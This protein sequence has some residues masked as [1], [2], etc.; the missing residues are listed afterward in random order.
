MTTDTLDWIAK[1]ADYTPDKIAVTSYDSEERYTYS[2]LDIYANRLVEKFESFGLQEGDRIAVLAEHSLHYIVL[3]SACQRSGIIIVPLNY[4]LSISDLNALFIDSN[5]ALLLYSETQKHKLEQLSV[6]LPRTIHLDRIK[7]YYQNEVVVKPRL[8][9]IKEKNPIFIFYTSGTTGQ[10]KGVIYTNKMMFW[11]SLNTSMQLGITFRDSTINT[12]PPYHTS[13]WNIFLTPL[14]HKGAHI[15]MVEKFDAERVLCLLELN[16]TTLFMALPTMLAMMQKTEVFSRVNLDHL[17]FII[18]GGETVSPNLLKYWKEKKDIAIRPGYGLTEAGPSIT[19][20]HHNIAMSKPDSIGKPNFYLKTK[21]VTSEGRKA[22][23]NEVGE[24]CIKGDIVTSG[25]WNNSTETNNK[26][27]NGWLHTGDLVMKDKDGFLFL[28][29]RKDDMYISGGENIHPQEI[30]NKI[31]A[32]NSVVK[33]TVL[34][35]EDQVWGQCG[36]AFVVLKKGK[37]ID[38][39]KAFIDKNMISF[40][41]PKHIIVLD[42]IP[43][44]SVGKIS[45]KKLIKYYNDYKAKLQS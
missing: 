5:P 27:K 24:F 42:D 16:R 18:S 10:P 41:R 32:C 23:I 4:R 2:Q 22:R 9:Q 25:Y 26:I 1:W 21:I 35:V 29:G 17:R 11:N 44:T 12:L 3:L 20:L 14:L 34:S 30:T 37:T 6:S 13:G 28:K 43:L 19:S 40:K 8:S 7:L 45:R 31:L 36:A 33:A 38:D 15:G 39:V